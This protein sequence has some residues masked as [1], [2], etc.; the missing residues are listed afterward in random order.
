[1]DFLILTFVFDFCLFNF[2]LSSMFHRDIG[3]YLGHERP[4]GFSGF[5]NENNLFLAIE[6]EKGVT[7]EKG[8]ELTSLIK[9]KINTVVIE[10]LNQFDT[11]VNGLINEK[12][13]PDGFSLS[14]GY[15]KE[16]IFY[17]KTV[18]QGQ[19]YIRRKSRLA[20][21]IGGNE[22]AS[23]FVEEEDVFVFTFNKFIAILGGEQSLNKKFDHRP[24]VEI[25]DEITPDLQLKDDL[26]TAALFIQLKTIQDM[27]KAP[28]K[29]DF[30]EHPAR[31]NF[32]V[33]LK[34]YYLRFGKQKTLTFVVVFI[35]ALIL[36]WSVGFGYQR[37]TEANSKKKVAAVKESISQKLSQADQ[38]AFLNMP[39][40]LALI[41]ESKTE[42]ADLK[43]S[44]GDKNTDIQ[45]LDQMIAD[46]EN[47]ILKKEEKQFSEVFDLTVDDKSAVG[48]KLYLTGDNLLIQ[49]K[50]RGVLYSFSLEK[51][52]L[53]KVQFNAVKRSNI[54]ASTADKQYFYVDGEGIYQVSAG[55]AKKVIDVD[56]DWGKIV[57]MD[58]F[59][60]N[61]YLLDQGKNEIWKYVGGADTFGNKNSYFAPGLTIDLSQIN[62]LAI[63]G[64]LYL[65]GNSVMLK[66]TSGLQDEFKTNLP[67][68]NTD[69]TKI[70]TNKDLTKVYAWDK[71]RETIYVMSKNGDYS[72][73][74]NSKILSSGSDFI[75]YKDVV[76]V[77]QGSKIYKID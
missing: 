1:M 17:L 68:S 21:L 75:V 37:R 29:D 10:N 19:I 35:L 58:V 20:L 24:I 8:R 72:E 55:Q 3:F 59:N 12:N 54:I 57:D 61:I 74:I 13:L 51:K 27:P 64:S 45:A 50:S 22:T 32:P 31:I 5:V 40:A 46:K 4:D 69:M 18:N 33:S 9:D 14:A 56:K 66:Y 47:K 70:F 6:I 34:E 41:N 62:S 53:D 52:S 42:V 30:F 73:Q 77:L 25:I 7:P 65:A 71:S 76:Y 15:L 67:D 49:D 11:F 60:G 44:V 63:D 16:N 28:P 39:S 43:K 36:I 26:G 23:G 48:D 2:D 38:V